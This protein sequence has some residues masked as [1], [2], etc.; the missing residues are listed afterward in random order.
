M[1][2]W[3]LPECCYA[4]AKIWWLYLVHFD[5]DAKVF[6]GS[7]VWLLR[8]CYMVARVIWKVASSRYDEGPSNPCKKMFDRVYNLDLVSKYQCMLFRRDSVL[9]FKVCGK[10]AEVPFQ[11]FSVLNWWRKGL[12]ECPLQTLSHREYNYSYHSKIENFAL[13]QQ[14][15]KCHKESLCIL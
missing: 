5:V 11:W 2:S 15:V 12:Q 3:W 14:E 13:C 8:H 10:T 1:W 6:W 4:V 7:S 9:C